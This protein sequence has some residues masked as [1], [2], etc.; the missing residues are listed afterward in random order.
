MVYSS[1]R[2]AQMLL[3]K[4]ASRGPFDR[5]EQVLLERSLAHQLAQ[6]ELQ[7]AMTLAGDGGSPVRPKR[8][9]G[10]DPSRW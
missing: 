9:G 5:R 10:M 6:R 4:W 1:T 7:W 2:P 3:E 8:A